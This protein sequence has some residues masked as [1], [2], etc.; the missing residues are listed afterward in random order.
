MPDHL[1]AAA[2]DG[3]I[4]AEVMAAIA[5]ALGV[6]APGVG[7]AVNR[8]AV[9]L[10]GE[11]AGAPDRGAAMMAAFSVPGVTTVH[12]AIHTVHV[13]AGEQTDVDISRSVRAAIAW[14]T[15]EPDTVRAEISDHTVI[16]TGTVR[17]DFERTALENSVRLV[18]GVD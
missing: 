15:E 8:G 3:A 16:L 2:D 4:Q 7:V 9:L 12:D 13:E 6:D 5:V 18:V 17:W 11:V 14:A 10:A 1:R